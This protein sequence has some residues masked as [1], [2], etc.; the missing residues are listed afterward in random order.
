M[1]IPIATCNSL[2][3]AREPHT[4]PPPD[5]ESAPEPDTELGSEPDNEPGTESGIKSDTRPESF[6]LLGKEPGRQG[7]ST[8]IS[9]ESEAVTEYD[10]QSGSDSGTSCNRF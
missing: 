2:W 9:A 8:E 5:N 4:E 3:S 10:L 1:A 6:I 7:H